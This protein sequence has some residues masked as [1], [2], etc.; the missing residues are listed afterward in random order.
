MATRN[1][2]SKSGSRRKGDA[3]P[4]KP[5]I[6]S[7]YPHDTTVATRGLAW[8]DGRLFESTALP[9]SSTIR[10]IDVP[11]GAYTDHPA[12]TEGVADGIAVAAGQLR[13]RHPFC[14]H[15]PG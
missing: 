14:R 13:N 3:E 5:R 10:Q 8:H 1:R 11:S 15:S 6:V 12:V 2:R 4:L 9:S 7:A